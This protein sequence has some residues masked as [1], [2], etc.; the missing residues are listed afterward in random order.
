MYGEFCSWSFLT[1]FETSEVY[2]LKWDKIKRVKLFLKH[3][4]L[5][6]AN[7]SEIKK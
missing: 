6:R 7:C 5:K 4:T 2:L 3:L 1:L